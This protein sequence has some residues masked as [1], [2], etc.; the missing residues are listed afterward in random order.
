MMVFTVGRFSRVFSVFRCS[1]NMEATREK[2]NGGGPGRSMALDIFF[3]VTFS[4]SFFSLSLF[5]ILGK[6]TVNFPS[7]LSLWP[8]FFLFL[9]LQYAYILCV[10]C[11]SLL[12]KMVASLSL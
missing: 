2:S 4:L 1:R 3:S 8:F 6:D 9:I 7:P 11:K 10:E 12:L 5:T